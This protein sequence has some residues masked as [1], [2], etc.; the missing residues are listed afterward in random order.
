[1]LFR[2]NVLYFDTPYERELKMGYT[3]V[4]YTAQKD[5]LYLKLDEKTGIEIKSH[6]DIKMPAIKGILIESKKGIGI[7][8][9]GNIRLAPPLAMNTYVE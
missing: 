7:Y 3:D 5:K 4:S 1:M 9:G 2:S 6:K 8:A